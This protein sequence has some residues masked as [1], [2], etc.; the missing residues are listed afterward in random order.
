MCMLFEK[1]YVFERG[2]FVKVVWGEIIMEINFY[3]I[4]EFVKCF[5]IIWM[6]FLSIFKECF[7]IL[8]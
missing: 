6:F 1:Y 5:Y 4:D 8:G 7:F 3:E 2:E